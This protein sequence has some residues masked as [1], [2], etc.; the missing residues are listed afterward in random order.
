M[1]AVTQIERNTSA[2]FVGEPTGSR[3][4]FVGESIPVILPYSKM[5]ATI[6]DLYWQNS[7]AMDYRNWIAPELYAPPTFALFRAKRDPAM[8]AIA[9]Y[10][11][12]NHKLDS[13]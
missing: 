4:N 5:R 6:S 13:P 9:D 7:V 12:T 1:C 11:P 2:I 10:I 8:E 3:P